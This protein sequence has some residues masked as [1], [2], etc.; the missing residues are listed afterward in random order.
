MYNYTYQDFQAADDKLKFILEAVKAYRLSD[1]YN[2]AIEGEA[3]FQGNNTTILSSTKN[4]IKLKNGKT[5]KVS[6]PVTSNIF[7]QLITQ[8]NA[9]LLSNGAQITSSSDVDLKPKFGRVFDRVLAQLG[10]N[11][12]RHAVSYGFWNYD[13]LTMFTALEFFT[14]DD[15]F[16]DT[17]MIGIRFIDKTN[18]KKEM[19]MLIELYENNGV[20][21]YII[22]GDAISFEAK[23]PYDVSI[24]PVTNDIESI[25]E[26]P[27]L[28]IV[29][30][31]GNSAHTSELTNPIKS[32]IDFLD[33]VWTNFG[34]SASRINIIYW[35]L[36][37]YSVTKEEALEMIADIQSLGILRADDDKFTAEAKAFEIP[38]ESVE[39]AIQIIE[40]AIYNDFGGVYM[41]DITG[42]SLTNVAINTMYDAHL[43]KVA[44]Y[45]WQPMDFIQGIMHVIGIE[46]T[47]NIQFKREVP[48]NAREEASIVL[49]H[50]SAGLFDDQTALEKS[51]IVIVD[52]V[53]TILNRKASE[54]LGMDDY[55][56][57]EEE[58]EQDNQP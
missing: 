45:E 24:R 25:V 44:R 51:P 54:Q 33:K 30:F 35:I 52:E 49:D 22:N 41:R 19:R 3:Y 47:E 28:P 13:R 5:L 9:T 2:S 12:L 18:G 42:G 8:Q 57:E 10:E 40:R 6:E 27:Q 1:M 38:S 36:K 37:N 11:A 39:K 14:L 58:P 56:E 55:S 21:K 43:K 50:Y 29:P 48:R 34:D 7:R 46:P 26:Y 16:Y 53:D 4:V 31:W 32:K 15:E 17:P 20:T 23:T